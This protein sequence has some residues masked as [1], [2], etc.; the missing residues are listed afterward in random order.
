[1]CCEL[2]IGV[3]PYFKYVLLIILVIQNAVLILSMRYSRLVEGKCVCVCACV[4]TSVYGVSMCM[5][6]VDLSKWS[7]EDFLTIQ[8]TCIYSMHQK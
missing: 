6:F 1:M 5:C 4:C 2:V 7:S 3:S 8:Y